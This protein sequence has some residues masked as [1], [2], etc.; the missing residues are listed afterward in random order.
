MSRAL[1]M[2]PMVRKTLNL[3]AKG[4]CQNHPQ[5]YDGLIELTNVTIET[6]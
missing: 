4:R 5:T 2:W 1:A 6:G 3:S